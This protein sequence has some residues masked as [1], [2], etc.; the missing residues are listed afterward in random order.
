LGFSKERKENFSAKG[1][2]RKERERERERNTVLQLQA[3]I[4]INDGVERLTRTAHK[5]N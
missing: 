3:Q 2:R 5:S 1:E 4:R